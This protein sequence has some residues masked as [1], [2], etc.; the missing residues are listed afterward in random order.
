MKPTVAD[1]GIA[2]ERIGVNVSRP[3]IVA[4][5]RNLLG[6]ICLMQRH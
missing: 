2:N 3:N 5:L 1:H 4:A 6:W